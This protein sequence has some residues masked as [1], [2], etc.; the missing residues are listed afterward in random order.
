VLSVDP[1]L[2]PVSTQ[3]LAT[4]ESHEHCRAV[5]ASGSH[6]TRSR[7]TTVALLP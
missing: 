6:E 2:T 1:H 4:D 7:A 5:G 3:A